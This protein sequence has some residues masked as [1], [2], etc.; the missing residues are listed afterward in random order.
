A[1]A[2]EALRLRA[3][4]LVVVSKGRII[5]RR[6]RNAPRLSL[7]GRPAEVRRRLASSRA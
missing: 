6:Q 2:T 3:E 5:S 7:P 4:R 1:N